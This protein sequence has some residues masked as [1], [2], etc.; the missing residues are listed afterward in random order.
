MFPLTNMANIKALHEQDIESLDVTKFADS[1]HTI[2]IIS[3][4]GKER[5]RVCVCSNLKISLKTHRM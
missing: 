3:H 1:E 2:H 5:E 4:H